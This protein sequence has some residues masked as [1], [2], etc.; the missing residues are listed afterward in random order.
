MRPIDRVLLVLLV[1]DGLMVGVLSVGFCYVRFW[2]QP[3]PFVA[4]AAG[5]V[6]AVLLWLAARH[7]DGPLRFGPLV[8]WS[9]VVVT[10]AVGGPGGDVALYVGGTSTTATLFLVVLG[11][12]IPAALIWSGRLPA[13]DPV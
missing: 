3:I 10:A 12:G 13:P 5:L 2:G 11:L 8:A 4:V 7:T 6:N 1:L 9:I